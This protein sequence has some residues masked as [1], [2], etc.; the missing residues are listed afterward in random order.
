MMKILVSTNVPAELLEMYKDFEITIPDH[1]L[2]YDAV[3]EIAEQYDAILGFGLRINDTLLEKGKNLK[4]VANFGV[5]YDNIDVKAATARGIAV[6]NTPTQVTDATAEHTIA[7]IVATMRHIAK[8]DR[9]VRQNIWK[10]PFMM[11]GMASVNGSTLGIVGFGRI[12]KAV[13]RKAQGLGMN[14]IYYDPYRSSEEIEKEYGV[15]YCGFEELIRNADCVTLHLPYTAEN[16]HLFGAETFRMMKPDA[17]FV[18]C[19]RGPI[20]DEE[21]LAAALRDH[22]IRGAGL[23]VYEHEPKV[24]EELKALDNVTLTP[25][26]AS[27]TKKARIGMLHEAMDG[28]TGVL[29]GKDVP[30]VVNHRELAER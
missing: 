18:N 13:C 24:S 15:T 5:G 26:A 19:A 6:V 21:A 1:R 9:E 16:H 20:V 28:L 3:S 10:P 22:V 23:D 11:D 29:S 4:A 14:V 25:H 30:N 12:G 2:T 17:F 8:F 27:A 7:L